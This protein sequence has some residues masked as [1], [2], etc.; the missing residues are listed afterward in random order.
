MAR[1]AA[2]WR[3]HLTSANGVDKSSDVIQTYSPSAGTGRWERAWKQVSAT[4]RAENFSKHTQALERA[5]NTLQH[6][7]VNLSRYLAQRFL[8]Q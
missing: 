2:V 3:W 7:L 8:V 6:A 4:V 5:R 1:L